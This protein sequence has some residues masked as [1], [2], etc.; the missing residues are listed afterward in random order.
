MTDAT[1]ANKR[2][3][4]VVGLTVAVTLLSVAGV[5]WHHQDFWK[6]LSDSLGIVSLAVS[7]YTIWEAYLA[8]TAAIDA[9]SASERVLGR[10]SK[11]QVLLHAPRVLKLLEL[12][13]VDMRTKATRKVAAARL[14]VAK[15]ALTE[16]K[17]RRAGRPQDES[18]RFAG[19]ID[20]A[21]AALDL[22]RALP[23]GKDK[24][25]E[26][27]VREDAV[28]GCLDGLSVHLDFLNELVGDAADELQGG[29]P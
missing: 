17:R 14:E 27:A 7:A 8:K 2:S 13:A 4:L 18:S 3:W 26:E 16:M 9:R 21:R 24:A 19:V 12:A 20:W 1:H 28:N 10:I 29:D 5:Y 22:C 15:D 6:G 25:R 11:L 23:R